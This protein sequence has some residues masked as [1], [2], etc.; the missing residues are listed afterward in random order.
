MTTLRFTVDSALLGELGERLVEH[1]HYALVE[2]VKNSYDADANHV[3]V[4]FIENESGISEIHIIDDGVGMNFDEVRDYWMHIATTNKLN[5]SESQKYGRPKTGS[6]GIG[7]FCCRRLGRMLTLITTGKNGNRFEKTEVTFN[8]LKFRPGTKVTGIECD[9]NQEIQKTGETGTT[10]IISDLIDEWSTKGYNYLKRQLA[11]LAANRGARRPGFEEDPG[12]NISLEAPGFEGDIRDL[13]SDLIKA[14]WGTL[15]AYINKGHKAVCELDA[16][17]IGKKNIVSEGKFSKLSDIRLEIGI[18]V[19][20]RGQMRDTSIVSIGNLQEILPEWGGVQIRCKG[21]RVY[22]YGDDDWLNIDVDRSYRRGTPSQDLQAFADTLRGV[23]PSRALLS[24][25]SMRNHIGTVEIGPEAKGFV[26]KLNREGFLRSDEFDQLREFVRFAINWATIYR[27]FYL[28]EQGRKEAEASR[29]SLQE[30]IEQPIESPKV[31]EAA[32]NYLEKEFK[33]IASTLPTKQRQT[34][35]TAFNKATDAILKHDHSNK[36][37]LKHLRLIASTSTLILIFSH[38]VKMLLGHLEGSLLQLENIKES[39]ARTERHR[40]D[41]IQ[42]WL[43]NSKGRLLELLDMTALIGV[44]SRREIPKSLALHDRVESASKAFKVIAESY[45]ITLDMSEIP[46]N[47][48]VG[49]ILEAELYAVLLNLFSNS[50]KSIIAADKERR[51]KISARKFGGKV[52]IRFMDTG[53]GL[54]PDKHRDIFIPFVAD[55][56]GKLYSG[57]E[58]RLNPEDKYIVGTG[59]GLG[60]SIVKEILQARNGDIRILPPEGDWKAVLEV[61]VP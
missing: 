48:V 13:R 45:G 47:I 32:V 19:L 44:D 15:K 38:E 27:D 60:L 50:I 56:D 54:N 40:I 3:T 41:D 17:G 58:K 57:L 59:S 9:G 33:S 34:V 42:N 31:V 14:G 43:R 2:L 5:R 26:M 8:W 36:E 51:I 30:L 20:D 37:E 46:P 4:K 10:L 16:L 21:F 22:P 6:K 29:V 35:S 7:R 23:D 18:M 28:R 39:L 1:V 53:L 61:E 49:P 12:F 25:L 55:I 52:Y 11:V 24:L